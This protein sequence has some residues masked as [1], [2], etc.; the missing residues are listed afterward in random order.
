VENSLLAAERWSAVSHQV[1]GLPYPIDFERAWKN[2]LFNQFHD[3]LAGTSIESVYEDV[4]NFYG[5]AMAIAGRNLNAAVQALAWKIHIE[6]ESDMLPIM[7]FNPHTW[8]SRVPVEVEINLA[9]ANGMLID[10]EDRVVPH[11]YVRSES[12]APWRSRLCFIAELPSLGYRVYRFYPLKSGVETKLGDS[13]QVN[14]TGLENE[15]FRL[16]FDPETGWIRSLID[17]RVNREILAGPGA[18]PVV[19]AD[20]SDTWSHNVF[21]FDEE[22]GAFDTA[23]IQVIEKGPVKATIR[24]ANIYNNS[25]LTQ[26]F[27]LYQDLDIMKIGVIVDW[28]EHNK[29]LKLRFPFSLAATH[30]TY[31]IPY[32]YIARSANG[33]ENPGL[34]WVDVTGVLSGHNQPYGLSL[35]NDGKYS[36]DSRSQDISN[37]HDI[38]LTVLRSPAYAHHLPMELA[39]EGL[40]NFMD[41]GR[42]SFR[43]AIFPHVGGWEETGVVKRAAEINQLPFVLLGT[44]H[45]EGNL[46]QVGSFLSVDVDNVVISV[47]KQAE[48]NNDLILRCY[49]TAGRAERVLISLP[50]LNRILTV[51]MGPCEI[52]TLRIPLEPSEE[53]KEVDLIECENSGAG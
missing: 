8:N 11:Q 41:Q 33:D 38:G 20:S 44:F 51:N 3:I 14:A 15:Y 39:S 37:F 46:P 10:V 19:I 6:P 32:G 7:V 24:V 23:S 12:A 9:P 50:L 42:Q 30:T 47:L 29:L 36:F 17:K 40:Y 27:T 45:P 16:G 13:L 52:K 34:N 21:R 35:L 49:E 18:R 28:R 43:Y 25:R 2:V 31:E 48:D 53:V 1:I 22:I 5:E 4:H 26:D